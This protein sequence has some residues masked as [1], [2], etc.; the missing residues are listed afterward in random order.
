RELRAF[1]TALAVA[2]LHLKRSFSFDPS[3]CIEYSARTELKSWREV[4]D[5]CHWEGIG[6]DRVAGRVTALNLSGQD[7]QINGFHPAL[8]RLTSLKYLNLD[9]AAP[10]FRPASGFETLTQLQVLRLSGCQLSGAIPP[11]LSTLHSLKKIDLSENW[12][13]G[14][15]PDMFSNF[16]LLETLVLDG[17]SFENGTLPL[18]ITQLK[19][20]K[21]LS[22]YN[23]NLFGVIPYSI[24]NLSSLRELDLN[25]NSFIG[26]LPWSLNNLTYLTVLSCDGCGLSGPVPTLTCL[27]RL[28]YISLA[29]NNLT[30]PVPL[31][32]EGTIYPNLTE[33]N[34]S[35]NSLSGTVRATLFTQPALKKLFLQMNNFSGPIGEFHNPSAT[36]TEVDLSS[37]HLSGLVPT[38]F[39][40]LTASYNSRLS[41]TADDLAGFNASSINGS[42][43]VLALKSCNLT[44]M[45]RAL[46]YL[47]ELKVLELSYNRIGGRIPDWGGVRRMVV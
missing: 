30:G 40:Q 29:N 44:R 4:S 7:I 27:T 12:L 35:N 32:H 10:P 9:S 5:C 33:V 22:L 17:N 19:N 34:L 21:V 3:S 47:P 11:S 15:V 26:S 13:T 24:G 16:P 46:R 14:S 2:L 28:K 38:S 31:S 25:S 36:L 6:C 42:I 20:L 23:M 45:P 39:S 1:L 8:F 37:N 18:G 41:A 43:S